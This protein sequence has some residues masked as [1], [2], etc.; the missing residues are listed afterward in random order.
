M[1]FWL[2]AGARLEEVIKQ[3]ESDHASQLDAIRDERAADNELLKQQVASAKACING[4][5][6]KFESADKR[7]LAELQKK[8]V[9]RTCILRV[10]CP[11]KSVLQAAF[12][13]TDTGQHVMEQLEPI[14]SHNVR[15]VGWYL[16]Q[17]PPMRRLQP[18]ETLV[19]A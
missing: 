16:Y 19:A 4:G 10:V 9:H 18:T 1:A 13:A 11:D 15:D 14:W 6:E 2:S 3:T 7:R 17:T 12:R 8:R 5:N